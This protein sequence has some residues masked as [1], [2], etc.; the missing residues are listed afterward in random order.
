MFLKSLVL[1]NWGNIPNGE[2][3]MGPINLVS[4]AN[5]SGKT[6]AADAL[7]T[8]MTA[9]HENLFHFN[10]GQEETT[11]R[12]RGG[13]RRRSHDARRRRGPR[14]RQRTERDACR[15]RTPP[16]GKPSS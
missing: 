2:F 13:K 11:Q 9:A 4:G 16:P 1:V 3:A 7:Q 12:G 5:G 14:L 8:L 10:P 6:T 15:L